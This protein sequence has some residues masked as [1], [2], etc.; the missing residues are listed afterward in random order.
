[1]DTDESTPMID[2]SIPLEER[3]IV[4]EHPGPARSYGEPM[5]VRATQG[6]DMALNPIPVRVHRQV[7]EYADQILPSLM[8]KTNLPALLRMI[9]VN[10][11]GIC[12]GDSGGRMIH[13]SPVHAIQ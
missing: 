7:S 13:M 11:V 8:H 10:Q 2:P 5:S 12:A 9:S 6:H 1:M 4:A 3:R